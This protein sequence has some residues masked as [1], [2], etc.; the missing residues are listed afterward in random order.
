MDN[1]LKGDGRGVVDSQIE[2]VKSYLVWDSHE[3][4]MENLVFFKRQASSQKAFGKKYFSI[5]ELLSAIHGQ[6]PVI[7][8]IDDEYGFKVDDMI[9]LSCARILGKTKD[10]K[11]TL[12]LPWD[13]LIYIG[14]SEENSEDRLDWW[15]Q[16][17]WKQYPDEYDLEAGS[18]RQS[19]AASLSSGHKV[20]YRIDLH[21]TDRDVYLDI[22]EYASRCVSKAQEKENL[23]P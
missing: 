15:K 6:N 5:A 19:D 7:K 22:L 11:W 18:C 13:E 1:Q 16:R 12:A 21:T 23:M 10:G 3:D 17:V 20:E 9:S 4:A 14:K 2:R 8:V